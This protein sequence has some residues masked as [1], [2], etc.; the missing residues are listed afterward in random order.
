MYFLIAFKLQTDM[1][2]VQ[3]R[4]DDGG[5]GGGWDEKMVITTESGKVNGILT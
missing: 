5:G 4:L 2:V 3:S 1:N